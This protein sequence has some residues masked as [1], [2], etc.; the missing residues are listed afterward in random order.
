MKGYYSVFNPRD[1]KIVDC[2]SERD[3]LTLIGMRN[4]RWDGHYYK[5]TP[6]Y[7]DIIDVSDKQLQ[8]A[9]LEIGGQRIPIQ[10]NLP[11]NCSEPFIPNFH[12]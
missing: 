2:G 1:E 4:R 8:P 11:V 6:A 10:Q 9:Y 5:F 3:A 7:G 12:D